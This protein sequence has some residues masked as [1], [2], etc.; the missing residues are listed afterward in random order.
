MVRHRRAFSRSLSCL[1]QF[2]L[3]AP[4]TALTSKDAAW[5]FIRWDNWDQVGG[6]NSISTV[7]GGRRH[8]TLLLFLLYAVCCT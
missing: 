1:F 2:T 5:Q 4:L 8:P 6:V 7:K 3:V